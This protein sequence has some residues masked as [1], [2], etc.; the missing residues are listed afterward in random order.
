MDREG[1]TN[2]IFSGKTEKRCIFQDEKTSIIKETFRSFTLFRLDLDV[3]YLVTLLLLLEIF[4]LCLALKAVV[5]SDIVWPKLP[6]EF[7]KCKI[8][9]NVIWKTVKIYSS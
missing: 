5:L 4:F 7:L 1:S 2:A 3:E 6:E 8:H 9:S